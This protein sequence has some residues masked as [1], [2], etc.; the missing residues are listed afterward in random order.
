MS[1]SW[2]VS[3]PLTKMPSYRS[4]SAQSWTLWTVSGKTCACFRWNCFSTKRH[5]MALET[6]KLVFFLEITGNLRIF[7]ITCSMFLKLQKQRSVGLKM[8][9]NKANLERFRVDWKKL[10]T[11]TL[12]TTRHI[13]AIHVL[14]DLRRYTSQ[15]VRNYSNKIKETNK[16][17]KNNHYLEVEKNISPK[18]TLVSPKNN[19]NKKQHLKQNQVMCTSPLHRTWVNSKTQPSDSG[20]PW[21]LVTVGVASSWDFQAPNRGAKPTNPCSYVLGF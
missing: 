17:V 4:L 20:L 5:A 7:E 15:R 9:M 1:S 11:H 2:I 16:S 13:Q 6:S 10:E 21:L 18:G 19:N 3:S 8:P 12:E 14:A